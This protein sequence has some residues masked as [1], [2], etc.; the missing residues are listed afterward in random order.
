MC[1]IEI[2]VPGDV[3]ETPRY[4]QIPKIEALPA[5]P[6][7]FLSIPGRCYFFGCLDVPGDPGDAIFFLSWAATFAISGLP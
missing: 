2:S 6:T 5:C 4:Y 1:R 7:L 3:A